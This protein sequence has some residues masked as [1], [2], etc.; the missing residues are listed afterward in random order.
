MPGEEDE[1]ARR[2]AGPG[3]CIVLVDTSIPGFKVLHISG[4]WKAITGTEA[5]NRVPF[6]PQPIVM[7]SAHRRSKCGGIYRVHCS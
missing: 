7:P 2:N 6:R 1:V 3:Q 4:E 5:H